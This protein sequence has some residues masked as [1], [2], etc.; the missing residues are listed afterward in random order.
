MGLSPWSRPGRHPPPR[1][2]SLTR[3]S[4]GTLIILGLGM[5]G[6]IWAPTIV[7]GD[8]AH[9][10]ADVGLDVILTAVALTLW[11]GRH[12]PM[13]SPSRGTRRG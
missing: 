3:R 6:T 11:R 8:R 1:S 9:L 4:S 2:R 13:R 7:L 12:G 10:G 5:L